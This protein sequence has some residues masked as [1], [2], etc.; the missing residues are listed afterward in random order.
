MLETSILEC[1]AVLLG[2][3]TQCQIVQFSVVWLSA[4]F[5]FNHCTLYMNSRH[6]WKSQKHR[7]Y[8]CYCRL[9]QCLH[10]TSGNWGPSH[11]H[12]FAVVDKQCLLVH[13]CFPSTICHLPPVLMVFLLFTHNCSFNSIVSS[14]E[15]SLHLIVLYQCVLVWLLWWL[16]ALVINCFQDVTFYMLSAEYSLHLIL[17]CVSDCSYNSNDK[18]TKLV[19]RPDA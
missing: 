4:H 13:F 3:T 10:F 6:I 7:E 5:Y 9:L 17:Y 8:V 19:R 11:I 1:S 2:L 16:I 18:Y 12:Y 15:Y 14:A